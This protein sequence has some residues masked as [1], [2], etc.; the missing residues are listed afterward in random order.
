MTM[1]GALAGRAGVV[2]GAAGGIGRGIALELARQGAVVV[3]SDLDGRRAAGERTVDLIGQF[4][5]SALFTPCD[6]VSPDSCDAL[7]GTCIETTGRLDFAVNNAGILPASWAGL[8]DLDRSW[9]AAALG[10]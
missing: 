3:V 5:G 9:Q 10:S 8:A 1:T 4:G 6:V 2:T 7:V